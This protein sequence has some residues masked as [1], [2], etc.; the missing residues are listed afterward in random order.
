M[1]FRRGR[2]GVVPFLGRITEIRALPKLHEL[3]CTVLKL[4]V[5]RSPP[6]YVPVA[7]SSY[8]IIWKFNFFEPASATISLDPATFTNNFEHYLFEKFVLHGGA[9]IV[10]HFRWA[11]E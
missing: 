10:T 7:M 2:R 1:D 9:T 8:D 3:L 11:P 4:S 5:S 6:R